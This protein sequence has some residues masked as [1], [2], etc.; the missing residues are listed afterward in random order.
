MRI[1]MAAIDW[2][3]IYSSKVLGSLVQANC[4][5]AFQVKGYKATSHS[6][7]SNKQPAALTNN[8]SFRACGSKQR[9]SILD[10]WSRLSQSA[11]SRSAKSLCNRVYALLGQPR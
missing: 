9:T 1:K 8:K 7:S 4:N 3:D 5:T 6:L 11:N 2:P 10:H